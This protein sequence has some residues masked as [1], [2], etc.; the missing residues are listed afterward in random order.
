MLTKW[1]H[2]ILMLL[3]MPITPW[4]ASDIPAQPPMLSLSKA[5]TKNSSISI[6]LAVPLKEDNYSSLT[7]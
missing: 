6:F 4:A 7:L 5:G 1:G 2:M 3:V